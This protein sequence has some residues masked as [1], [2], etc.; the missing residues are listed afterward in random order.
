MLTHRTRSLQRY[1]WLARTLAVGRSVYAVFAEQEV[2]A[3]Q[4]PTPGSEVGRD[5]LTI[6]RDCIEAIRRVQPRGPYQLVGFS[7]GG[8][9]ALEVARELERSGERVALVAVLDTFLPG[10]WRRRPLRRAAFH[11]GE[12]NRLGPRHAVFK[13]RERFAGPQP[14]A[15]GA[16]G[17]QATNTML[18]RNELFRR[19]ARHA[20]RPGPYR[21]KILLFRASVSRCPWHY[22]MDPLRGWGRVARG[23]LEVF[24]VPCRHLEILNPKYAAM[25]AEKLE[26][27]LAHPLPVERREGAKSA[28]AGE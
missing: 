13:L 26:P 7:F 5:I 9:V 4:E 3:V 28:L 10:T 19:Q 12:L 22:H 15:L 18:A 6:A 20:Y 16:P 2:E 24:D 23:P 27:H 14:Q 11:L 1:R 8:C 17:E 21:G 25:V